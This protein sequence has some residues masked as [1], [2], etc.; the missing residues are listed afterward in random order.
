MNFKRKRKKRSMILSV[1]A[2]FTLSIMLIGCGTVNNNSQASGGQTAKPN[3]E[4]SVLR[5]GYQKSGTLMVLKAKGELEKKLAPFGT[6]VQWSEF[7]TGISV[8]EALGTGSI[9]FGIAGDAPVLFGQER[10]LPF[11]YVASEPSSPQS[12]GILVKKDSPIQTIAD[13]KGKKVAFN[14][15]S[16]SQY[17]INEALAS[18]GLTLNDIE[19]V[20]LAP[21]DAR[22]AFERGS[23]DAWVVWDPFFSAAELAGNRVLADGKG[24]VIYRTFYLGG[25]EFAE[26][27]PEVLQALVQEL[28]NISEWINQNPGEVAKLLAAET[29]LD[30]AVWEQSLRRRPLTIKLIDEE[31]IQDQQ[32]VADTFLKIGLVSKKI[33]V[34]ENVWIPKNQ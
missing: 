34:R 29:Q 25:K 27:H 19:P 30:V 1:I 17:L 22:I 24:L 7:N 6:K 3:A 10:G 20:Y 2:L 28:Q 31:I 26:K 5:I 13:L 33:N 11:L 8:M 21:P 15:A 23:A 9:D 18:V 14:K 32:S 4:K 12:E 16:I